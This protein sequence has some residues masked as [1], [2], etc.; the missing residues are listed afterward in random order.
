VIHINAVSKNTADDKIRQALRRFA[1]EHPTPATVILISG[2]FSS[3]SF[4]SLDCLIYYFLYSLNLTKT[5]HIRKNFLL[6]NSS[7]YVQYFISSILFQAFMMMEI[8]GT[9]QRGC[10]SRTCVKEDMIF[11]PRGCTS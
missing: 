9:R 10:L 3:Y 6:C 8:D 2:L 4:A 11:V 7:A 1:A 5:L